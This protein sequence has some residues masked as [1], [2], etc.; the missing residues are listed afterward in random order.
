MTAEF[1]KLDQTK[2][3][4]EIGRPPESMQKALSAMQK[5]LEK[6]GEAAESCGVEDAADVLEF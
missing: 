4:R 6:L 1:G 2:T 3:L 5:A